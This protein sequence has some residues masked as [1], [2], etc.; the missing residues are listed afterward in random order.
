VDPKRIELQ[1]NALIISDPE[2]KF[3]YRLCSLKM[4]INDP[5]CSAERLG[6][7]M[8]ASPR[9]I[10]NWI[11]SINNSGTISV[12]RDKAKPGRNSW[13]SDDQLLE[14][15]SNILER[16]FSLGIDANQWDGKTLSHYIKQ[17]YGVIIEVRQFQRLFKKLGFSLKR[18][19]T[20]VATGDPAKK[21]VFKK[22]PVNSK[23]GKV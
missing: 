19:R 11:H 3:I 22:T 2:S 21:R 12:L 1:I 14:L 7:I 16:P 17:R 10:A 6:K 13:L 20:I 23:K 9:S 5:D 4:F 18:D 15:Q 8:Q